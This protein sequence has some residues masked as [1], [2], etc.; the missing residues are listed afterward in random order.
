M[1]RLLLA[2]LLALLPLAAAGQTTTLSPW[3]K[4]QFF[5][6]NSAE[7]TGCK[8]FTYQAGTTT[9]QNTFTDSTGGT[10]NAN[11]VIMNTRGEA[12]VWLT[13][14][15]GYKFVLSPSTDT[16]PPTNPFWTVD[17]ITSGAGSAVIGVSPTV[18]NDV[19]LWDN[20]SATQLIDSGTKHWI[21]GNQSP[22]PGA[23]MKIDNLFE[24][25]PG[26]PL[27]N[28]A[29]IWPGSNTY[30]FLGISKEITSSD[31]TGTGP[32][33]ITPL[34]V[35]GNTTIAGA[36]AVAIVSDCVARVASSHCWGANQVSR[37]PGT[38]IT[39]KLVGDEID[40]DFISGSGDNPTSDSGG[41]FINTYGGNLSTGNGPGLLIGGPGP[42][43]WTN[44]I[45]IAQVIGAGLYVNGNYSGINS[46]VDSET[47]AGFVK[48]AII[49][50]NNGGSTNQMIEWDGG[51]GAVAYMD[52]SNNFWLRNLANTMRLDVPTGKNFEVTINGGSAALLY[53]DGA[54]PSA[55]TNLQLLVNNSGGVNFAPI[56]LGAANSGGTG[57]RSLIA[58]N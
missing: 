26:Y 8:L 9:K 20:T 39:V 18:V 5:D 4:V 7:C 40:Q 3:P 58:P 12:N 44:G 56:T 21:V 17:Q 46:L 51:N 29:G 34:F 15:Q 30:T 45:G 2:S 32:T 57:F 43:V 19:A 6:N 41:L 31:I 27:V 11:P 28:E 52:G 25:S 54:P 14:G 50:G 33:P 13:P 22:S 38:G 42:G 36:D 10:P 1:H 35:Y 53:V 47:T 16:D 37:S 49:I 23:A 24:L 48:A 55:S